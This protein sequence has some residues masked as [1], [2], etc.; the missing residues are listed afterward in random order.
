MPDAP[1]DLVTGA[2]GFIGRRLA[3]RLV[4]DG[5]RVR[6]LCLPGD[7]P[8]AIPALAALGDRLE[9][10]RGDLGDAASLRAAA[11]GARRVFHLAAAVGDWGPEAWFVALNVD[12][13]RRVLEA[14]AAA[15]CE[16]VVH[17]SSIVVYGGQLRDGAPDEDA[18]RQ[19]GVGPYGRT[20]SAADALA[21]DWHGFGR[22]PVTVVRPGNVWGPGS[23]LWV[24]EI[25]R[26]LRA[27]LALTLDG[28]DGDAQLAHVD[29][30][31]DVLS[32]AAAAP[33]AAGRVYNATDGQGV[34]WRRYFADLARL[35]GAAAPRRSL[36]TPVAALAAGAM[37]GAW[38]LARRRTRP[39]LTREA[40]ALL[41]SRPP[42]PCDRARRELGYVPVPYDDAL[43]GLARALG[44]DPT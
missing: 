31:V 9:V 11:A 38:R 34:T 21:L 41:A 2:T 43:A 44:S 16:R 1:V 18:P 30:V 27:N 19:R 29:G 6:A 24:D 8:A 3:A 17:V 37:E 22:V 32:R 33:H 13:T 26:L 23:R 40:V 35:V 25:A 14:A 39:L 20:K 7:D 28:G 12:G 36:P 15:G 42:V 5:A 4:A 10:A